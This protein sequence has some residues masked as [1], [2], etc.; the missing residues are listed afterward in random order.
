[1][2]TMKINDTVLLRNYSKGLFEEKNLDLGD[3][4]SAKMYDV[5]FTGTS[6]LLNA[7][8][9]KEKPVAIQFKTVN[10]QTVGAAIVQYFANENPDLVGN[11]SLVWTFNESDI[12]A[13][14]RVI[15]FAKETTVY[16]FYRSAGGDKYGMC[17]K[18]D[19]ILATCMIYAL[20]MLKKYLDENAKEG[21]E[22]AV[23]DDGIFLARVA[24]ENGE[25]VFALEAAG[26]LKTLIKD[27]ASIE[28]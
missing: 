25:K 26:E 22:V 10:G 3:E 19:G 17:F 23:E 15:D 5:L 6:Y 11:W 27:D 12:P 9:S 14:A 24:V 21:S 18:S 16:N 1:M 8:K 7:A 28:K 4:H 13:D 20:E 2:A